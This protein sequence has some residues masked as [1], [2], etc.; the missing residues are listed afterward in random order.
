VKD[1]AKFNKGAHTGEMEN[2]H[3]ILVR[4]SLRNCHL[5]DEK[6]NERILYYTNITGSEN[7][8]Y[9]KLAHDLVQ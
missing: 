4:R 9:M 7:G 5:E 1:H 3:R 6:R 2:A 8:R